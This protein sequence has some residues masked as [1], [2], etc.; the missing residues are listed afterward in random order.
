MTGTGGHVLAVSAG[1]YPGKVGENVRNVRQSAPP[2][3]SRLC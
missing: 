1:F 2:L 3:P